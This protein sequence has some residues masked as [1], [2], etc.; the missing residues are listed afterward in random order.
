METTNKSFDDF[1]DDS[2]RNDTGFWLIAI[3][4]F[5]SFQKLKSHKFFERV[6]NLIF[7]KFKY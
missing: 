6:Y 5:V 3:V 4:F 1:Q 2:W 7:I